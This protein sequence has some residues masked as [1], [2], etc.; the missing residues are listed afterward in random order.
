M[1]GRSAFYGC[2]ALTSVEFPIPI[3]DEPRILGI[4]IHAFDTTNLQNIEFRA[5]LT[6][7]GKEFKEQY[8]EQLTQ[9]NGEYRVRKHNQNLPVDQHL[10]AVDAGRSFFS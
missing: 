9:Q 5:E 7:I 1:I 4:G 10:G 2:E 6:I 3:N 8:E